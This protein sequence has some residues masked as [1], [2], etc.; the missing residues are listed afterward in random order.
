MILE[1]LTMPAFIEGL[2]K[3]RTIIV[4]FGAVEEHG[5]HLPLGTD[6]IH[7]YELSKETS[8]HRPLFV[9][10]PV[11]Y[12][13]CRSTSQHAGTITISGDTLKRL[14]VELATSLYN[15]G[16]RNFILLSG[17]AGGTHMASLTDAG[18]EIL[19]N[20]E[21]S[22]VAVLS[23]LD[24]IAEIPDGI[25]ETE[26]DSHAGEVETSLMLHLRPAH[27]N[28]TSPEEYPSFPTPILARNKKKFWPG[29][30]WGNPSKASLEKGKTVLQNE[31]EVLLRLVKRIES[32]ED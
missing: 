27:I 13:L 32:F 11:W 10:P 12:G 21:G 31:V 9:A 26:N 30:V 15:Q 7:S 2:T 28:G 18:E 14:A 6:T 1:K 16:L 29:G 3:T 17:H 5:Q 22:R 24:L 8:K 4:P 23:I 25:V 20:L 19:S